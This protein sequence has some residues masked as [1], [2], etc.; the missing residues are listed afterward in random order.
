[1]C[2]GSPGGEKSSLVGRGSVGGLGEAVS[3]WVATT[4]PSNN[5]EPP[6]SSTTK[7]PPKNTLETAHSSSNN[8]HPTVLLTS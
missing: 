1:M 6:P 3:A 5:D 4:I 8:I 7:P 2:A